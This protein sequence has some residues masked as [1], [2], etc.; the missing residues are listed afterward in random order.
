[1]DPASGIR[2]W[3]LVL[4]LFLNLAILGFMRILVKLLVNAFAVTVTAYLLPG[5]TLEGYLPAFVVAVVLGVL[6]TIFKPILHLLALPITIV[7]LG[8]FSLVINAVVV[9]LTDALVAGFFV[10]GFWWALGFSLVLSIVS[11]FLHSLSR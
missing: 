1:M 7:T 5:V 2:N 8:L 4:I 11:W 3:I 9:M 6:N 10:A